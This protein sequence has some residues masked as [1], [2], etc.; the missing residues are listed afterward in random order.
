MADQYAKTG[1]SKDP[2]GPLFQHQPNLPKLPVPTLEETCAKYLK[3]LKP[4][5]NDADYAKS[6]A[7]VEEF[8]KPGGVGENLQGKLEEKARNS[9]TS[10]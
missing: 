6:K 9:N 3:T 2:A 1:P 8:C 5:L 10:W 4:F 7:A